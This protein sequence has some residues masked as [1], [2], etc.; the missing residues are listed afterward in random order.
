MHPTGDQHKQNPETGDII[1]HVEEYPEIMRLNFILLNIFGLLPPTRAGPLMKFIYKMFIA[2]VMLMDVL[3]LLGQVLAVVVYW[4]NLELISAIVG[5][6]NGFA[7]AFISCA[8]FVINKEKILMLV[9]IMRDKFVATTKSKYMNLIKKADSQ[10]VV[11]LY[12]SSP[13]VVCCSFSWGVATVINMNEF[14]NMETNNVTKTEQNVDK[15]VFVMWT[16]F[17]VQQSPQFEIFSVFQICFVC[18]G[19]V[20]SYTL[21]VLVLSLMS[22]S[23]AQFNILVAM[24]NDMHENISDNELTAIETAFSANSAIDGGKVFDNETDEECRNGHC[25]ELLRHFNEPDNLDEDKFQRYL[26]NCIKHHES[27]IK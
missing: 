5:V 25:S 21:S 16:P 9:D 15:M 26:I 4:G 27:M 23:A 3:I 10:V 2:A 1:V 13:V 22:H 14:S 12:L 8:Y 20:T 6:M 19:V 24:L 18:I 17:D 11:Y 7:V